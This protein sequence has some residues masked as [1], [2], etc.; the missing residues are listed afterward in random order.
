MNYIVWHQ[1]SKCSTGVNADNNHP[2]YFI[3]SVE[4]GGILHHP[5]LVADTVLAKFKEIPELAAGAQLGSDEEYGK[6]KP[7]IKSMADKPGVIQ[8]RIPMGKGKADELITAL[9]KRAEALQAQTAENITPFP[10]SSAAPTNIVQAVF[11]GL[12]QQ[13]GVA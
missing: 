8:I 1:R 5:N 4:D 9:G 6:S 3:I 11:D 2:D 13:F 10:A 7:V 12:K